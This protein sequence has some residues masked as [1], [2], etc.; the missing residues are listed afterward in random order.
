MK[1]FARCTYGPWINPSSCA[2]SGY[3]NNFDQEYFS[4]E[5]GGNQV[6]TGF[7]S[8]HSNWREDRRWKVRCCGVSMMID[9]IQYHGRCTK[10]PMLLKT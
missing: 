1:N 6:V 7:K 5:C 8:Y 4:Y 3:V 2:W 9:S 10:I